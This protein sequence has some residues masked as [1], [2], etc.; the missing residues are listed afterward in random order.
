MM[1]CARSDSMVNAGVKQRFDIYVCTAATRDYALEAWRLLD[2]NGTLIPDSKRSKRIKSDSRN[3][4]LADVMGIG[5]FPKSAQPNTSATLLT[6][7]EYT[8]HA[9]CSAGLILV[10]TEVLTHELRQRCIDLHYCRRSF[11]VP[12][13]SVDFAFN[14]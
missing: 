1:C 2:P 11:V 13:Y 8:W 7:F 10:A 14:L 5:R 4:Y 6:P 3:K 12:S 9:E